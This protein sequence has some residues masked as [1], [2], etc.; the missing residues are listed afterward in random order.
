MD[1]LADADP[2]EAFTENKHTVQ[3]KFFHFDILSRPERDYLRVYGY[4][5]RR[6]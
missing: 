3:Y 1:D 4:T 5:K 2:A 6:I